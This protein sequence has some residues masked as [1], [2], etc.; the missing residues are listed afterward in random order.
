MP[1]AAEQL[2]SSVNFGA[3]AKATELKQRII[4]TLLAL[5]VYRLGT[6]LPIP[7]INPGA[8]D[9]IFNQ[10]TGGILGMF[11]MFAGGALSRMSIFERFGI[12]L[13]LEIKTIGFKNKELFPYD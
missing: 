1:S 2:A 10:N 7:G 9:D 12:M 8:L 11:D 6:Y 4:F 5:I 3:I 13:D